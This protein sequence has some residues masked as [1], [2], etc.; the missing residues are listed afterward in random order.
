[1]SHEGNDEI[2]DNERDSLAGGIVKKYSRI[3][4]KHI[5]ALNRLYMERDA[6]KYAHKFNHPAWVLM[7]PEEQLVN[8]LLNEL[9][10]VREIHGNGSKG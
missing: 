2:I 5:E 10:E 4:T 3:L 8:H 1:M 6:E 9:E 7:P